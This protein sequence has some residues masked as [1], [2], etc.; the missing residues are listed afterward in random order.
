MKKEG[1]GFF[2]LQKFV[3]PDNDCESPG[4]YSL[5]QITAISTA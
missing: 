2:F 3:N 1:T 5:N 4:D